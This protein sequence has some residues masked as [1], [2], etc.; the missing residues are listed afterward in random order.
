MVKD[1]YAEHLKDLTSQVTML[2]RRN[3]IFLTLEL[4]SF[5]LFVIFLYEYFFVF[6]KPVFILMVVVCIAIYAVTRFFDRKNVARLSLAER[7]QTVYENELLYL[8]GD[9]SRFG[10][11]EKYIDKHHPFS[12]DMDLFGQLSLFNRI[13]RTVTTGGSDSL[14]QCLISLPHS[15]DEV[16]R[17]K[18]S[19]DELAAMGDIRTLFMASPSS[20]IDTA[21]ISSVLKNA[22]STRVSPLFSNLLFLCVVYV[23]IALL[24]VTITL[25]IFTPLSA[26]V[27]VLIALLMLFMSLTV[28]S[29]TLNRI[30]RVVNRLTKELEGYVN[31]FKVLKD[32]EFKTH[33]DRQLHQKL[34]S[35]DDNSLAAL[36][37]LTRILAAIDRRGN[38]LG[39]IFANAFFFSD[40]FLVRRFTRWQQTNLSHLPLWIDCVSQFDAM[41]SMATFRFNHPEAVDAE[42]LDVDKIVYQA[43][44]LYHPFI[45]ID[46]AVKNDFKVDDGTFYIITGANMAGKSTFLRS[47]GINYILAMNGMPVFAQSLKISMFNIFTSMCTTDDL[48]HGISYFNA[49]LIRLQQLI[50]A[51]KKSEHTL[52]IL[53]EILKGTNSLDKLNGS[54]LFLES[55]LSLPVSGVIATHDL[56]LSKMADSDPQHFHNY[57]FEVELG[58]DVTYSY[59]ITSGVARNQNATFLLNKILTQVSQ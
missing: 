6:H 37:E 28:A 52:I 53:D 21:K 34:F 46:K 13:N 48:T 23:F 17:R 41:M 44:A 35:E 20:S 18:E 16:R 11:G 38:I 19:I 24:F 55:I 8:D 51:C 25:S 59:R 32:I 43:M 57:C 14:A 29:R 54:R 36:H 49:E 50:C 1:L 31:L 4:I 10:D 2:K 27:T 56:E 58:D 9:F 12:T 39:L 7:I 33:Y 22:S 26:N 42:I 47:V 3:P 15:S 30:S 45:G 5:A 40:F